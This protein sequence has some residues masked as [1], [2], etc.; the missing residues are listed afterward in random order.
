[1]NKL[2]LTGFVSK[3]SQ[4]FNEKVIKFNLVTKKNVKVNDNWEEKASFHQL[5]GFGYFTKRTFSKG[6]LIS[7]EAHIDY[8]NYQKDGQT[9]Y[10]TSLI[11]DSVEVLKKGQSSSQQPP[12]GSYA[13]NRQQE[14]NAFDKKREDESDD[15]PY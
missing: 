10:Q 3:D 14:A 4:V 2:L 1:M 6:D 15:L 5:T 13:G 11:L 9:V 8:S 7:V 12:A